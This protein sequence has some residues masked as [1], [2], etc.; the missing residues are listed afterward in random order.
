MSLQEN[1]ILIGLGGTGGKVLK[2]FRKRLFAEFNAEERGKLPIGFIYVDSTNEMMR[3]NDVTFRVHGQDASFTN[4]EF[5]NIKGVELETV[6]RN[7]SG[8]PGLKGFIG[9]PEVMQ[10]TIGSVSAAA[11]QKRKAGRILFG[12]SVQPF[13]DTLNAQYS[14]VRKFSGNVPV[15]V[16]IFTGLAGGTGSGSIID[17]IAQTR[18]KF[19]DVIDS[20]WTSGA[21][22][23]VYC[24]TPELN[25]PAGC[26]AGRYHANGY[27]ALSELNAL[28][29][30]KYKP[31]DV[32]GMSDRIS[33]PTIANG[34]FVYSNINEHG[35]VIDSH[36][37]LPLIVADF[38]Y[39]RVFLD[40]NG[41]TLDF[42]RSYSFENIDSHRLENSEKA[43]TGQIDHV[44]SKAFGSFGIKRVIIPEE[45]I[46][47]YFTYSFGQ[48][49][50]LQIRYNNWNDDL[51]FRETPAN[52]DFNSFVK[53]KEQLERWRMT[54]KH[55]TL[56]KPILK[57]DEKKFPGFTDYWNSVIPNWTEIARI[58]KLP[59]NK[60][61]QC[62]AE[63]YEKLFRKA[64]VKSFFESKMQAKEEHA[65]EIAEL[66]ELYMFDRWKTGDLSLHN[67]TQ[68]IDKLLESVDAR[69]KEFEGKI[70]Q[71]NQVIDQLELARASNQLEWAS[72]NWL[73]GNVFGKK[74]KLIT[75]H[76]TIL[77]QI[78]LRKT[79]AEGLNFGVNVL[80]ALSN[81][82]NA[83]RGRIEK[84][85]NTVHDAL[86]D[87]K[88][89]IGAR[90][91]DN[92]SMDL[93]EAIIRYYNKDA[94]VK[95]TKEVIRD[96]K[97][98]T[99]IASAFREEIV[100]QTGE[101]TF[102]RANASISS[103]TILQILDTLIREKTVVIHNEIL[104]ANNEK[105]IN[106][107]I[108]EQLNEQFRSDDELRKF[109]TDLIQQSGVFAT[110]NSTEI[111]R[112]VKNN[113]ETAVGTTIFR[114]LILIS[115]PKI[116]GNQNVQKFADKLTNHLTAAVQG[117]V[118]VKVD[119]NGLRKNEITISSITYCFPLRAVK[120]L[121]FLREKYD[122][123][124][125][126]PNEA[127]QNRT[128]LHTEGTGEML[129]DLF[130]ADEMQPSGIRARY[131]PYLIV[132]YAL[133][134]I[135][136]ADR[137]DGT[138]KSA[139]G[140]VSVN[141]LGEE[142]LTP[143]ADKFS[144]IPF[145]SNVFTE[146]F[147]EELREKAESE[148]K[149]NWLHQAQRAELVKKVQMLYKDVILPEYNNK[150]GNEDCKFFAGAAEKAMD[151]I[152]KI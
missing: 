32:T 85:T 30:K 10:K 135:K 111:N 21:D 45:E 22:I 138:G 20:A 91:R 110:F 68:L 58:D 6:F 125:T 86:D 47:E 42:I 43:K 104:I 23:V 54:D 56:D 82:L 17:V 49:A 27:A 118:I 62:C 75:A 147:G 108:L 80:A 128:V 12:G 31:H 52:I 36:N 148:I 84:F 81:K 92:G 9:D 77:S 102:A 25:P 134:F 126:N 141:R 114:K 16:H 3:P 109:A 139:W 93:Q 61:E 24:M 117:N 100:N 4:S 78:Y 120:D 35:K 37:Q 53:E 57:S 130:V 123:L 79:E 59:L 26:D 129:P 69:R 152:E 124:V 150:K 34:V 76:S 98:Q 127:R 29:A 140:T 33:L 143:F 72:T 15:T 67:L 38:A 63:G 89:Q 66:T 28:L 70:P 19:P 115:L 74:N 51:G 146:T 90:C 144:E 88:K 107:S 132:A 106:R 99:N 136:Y 122:Y 11:G 13:L 149:A 60:L 46:I 7:P 8:F 103:D 113:P 119:S 5:V 145:Y 2:A 73:S 97:R 83:L 71:W 14:K 142:V 87:V 50:L 94:V 101:Q 95:F 40:N 116:D 1:H 96:K 48:Q 64:G 44:R 105:I 151:L 18:K 112:T 39:S 137:E 65:A 55:L 131:V 121:G 133:G 41:N